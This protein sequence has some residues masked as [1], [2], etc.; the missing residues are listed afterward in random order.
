MLMVIAWI[1]ISVF[2]GAAIGLLVEVAKMLRS[3]EE[4]YSTV[5]NILAEIEEENE[6]AQALVR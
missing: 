3:A 6:R 4:S 1:T 2:A 5:S